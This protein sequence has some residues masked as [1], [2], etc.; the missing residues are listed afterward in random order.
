[1]FEYNISSKMLIMFRV[2]FKKPNFNTILQNLKKNNPKDYINKAL[3]V[4]HVFSLFLEKLIYYYIEFYFNCNKIDHIFLNSLVFCVKNFICCVCE[5]NLENLSKEFISYYILKKIGKPDTIKLILSYLDYLFKKKNRAIHL[6]KTYLY[7]NDDLLNQIRDYMI[8]CL[9]QVEYSLSVTIELLGLYIVHYHECKNLVYE[10]L[11]KFFN[12]KFAKLAFLKAELVK[13]PNYDYDDEIIEKNYRVIKKHKERLVYVRANILQ[14]LMNN[15]KINE[16]RETLQLSNENFIYYIKPCEYRVLKGSNVKYCIIYLT[17][18]K[19]NLLPLESKDEIFQPHNEKLT[20]IWKEKEISFNISDLEKIIEYDYSTRIILVFKENI[21]ISLLFQDTID[22]LNLIKRLSNL[23]C[24]FVRNKVSTVMIYIFNQEK[25][26]LY[27]SSMKKTN[28]DFRREQLR[29]KDPDEN[30]IYKALDNEKKKRIQDEKNKKMLREI[31]E[32]HPISNSIKKNFYNFLMDFNPS[33]YY[34]CF[35]VSCEKKTFWDYIKFW[36]KESGVLVINK[37]V[38]F[39]GDFYIYLLKENFGNLKDIRHQDSINNKIVIKEEIYLY[40]TLSK[41]K[42]R[43]LKKIVHNLDELSIILKWN[44][45][46]NNNNKSLSLYFSQY[47]DYA[48]CYYMLNDIYLKNCTNDKINKKTNEKND[49]DAESEEFDLDE[50]SDDEYEPEK[51]SESK[52][53]ETTIE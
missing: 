12:V 32:D 44:E 45:S 6:L 15:K 3:N 41:F 23:D 13:G 19:I 28:E 33:D 9:Y 38:L 39:I 34:N 43:D 1:M 47:L 11:I 35:L 10:E 8:S 26:D 53:E 30:N 20:S 52:R 31:K 46:E 50:E 51:T 7:D 48:I 42:C 4:F 27:V 40:E 25:D 21:L 5:L 2:I 16:I 36:E 24:F 18:N 49:L 37:K 17:T 14:I 22:K 29:S